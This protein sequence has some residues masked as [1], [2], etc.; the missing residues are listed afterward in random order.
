MY[1]SHADPYS[2]NLTGKCPSKHAYAVSCKP[3]TV[4]KFLSKEVP[5]TTLYINPSNLQKSQKHCDVT[6]KCDNRNNSFQKGLS[7]T[8]ISK[9]NNLFQFKKFV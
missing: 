8:L 7:K 2:Y 1:I 4:S 5:H 9:L 6:F 3:S